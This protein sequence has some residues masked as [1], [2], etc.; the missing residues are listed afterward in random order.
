MPPY[1]RVEFM[2]PAL[3]GESLIVMGSELN[4][5]LFVTHELKSS[6]SVGIRG[7]LMRAIGG[8]ARVRQ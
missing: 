2:L 7:A 3:Y 5:M 6:S 4:T 1:C 8:N